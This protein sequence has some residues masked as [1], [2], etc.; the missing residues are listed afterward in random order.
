MNLMMYTEDLPDKGQK[1]KC[2]CYT[3]YFET[4]LIRMKTPL[5]D[6]IDQI[7]YKATERRRQ[8][9]MNSSMKYLVIPGR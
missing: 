9:N 1:E 3:H 8:K 4:I 6:L 2:K 5:Q 7:V